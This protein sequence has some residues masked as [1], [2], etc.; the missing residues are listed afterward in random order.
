MG[1]HRGA[2]TGRLL[3][4][5]V[6]ALLTA[7]CGGGDPSP[8]L[9]ASSPA[10]QVTVTAT[11]SGTV[12]PSTAGLT[13]AETACAAVSDYLDGRE[14][15]MSL[16]DQTALLDVAVTAGMKAESSGPQFAGLGVTLTGLRDAHLVVVA[17]DPADA[18]GQLQALAQ[19]RPAVDAANAACH[20][21]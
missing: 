14:S 20:L 12:D 10:P 17:S 8:V 7:G 13:D 16:P 21:S 3:T 4:L 9:E 15:G 18:D 1:V 5:A 19:F 2:V 6:C 11:P